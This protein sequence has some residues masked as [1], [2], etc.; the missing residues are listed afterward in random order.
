MEQLAIYLLGSFEVRLADQD[1]GGVFRTRKERALLAYLAVESRHP[2]RRE[3]LAE[4]L[5]PERPEGYART[6]LRQALLGLRK[7]IG[8]S[9]IQVTDELIHFRVGSSTWLDASEFRSAYLGTLSHSHPSLDSC[10]ECARLLEKAVEL[11]RGDFLDE[12]SLPDSPAFQEWSVFQREQHRRYLLAALQSLSDYHK[13]QRNYE[14]AY[15]YAWRYV[16]LAPLEETAYRQLMSVLALSGRR[17]AALEQFNACRSLLARELGVEP[18]VETLALYELIRSGQLA[19][20]TPATPRMVTGNLPSHL[21]SFYGREAELEH[22]EHCLV[23]Q[24]CRLITLVGMPGAGKTRLAMQ[25]ARHRQDLFHDGVWYIDLKEGLPG[26][27]LAER[28]LYT[29]G[30]TVQLSA[31]ALEQLY[32]QLHKKR[33]LLVVDRFEGYHAETGL[34]IE[35]LRRE[36]G[37]KILITSQ[38]RINYQSACVFVVGGLPYQVGDDPAGALES[39]AVQL[40]LGR[41]QHTRSGFKIDSHNLANITKICRLVEGLPLGVELA[42]SALPRAEQ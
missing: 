34:L 27:G 20:P 19:E 3:A 26:N 8:E 11:Y 31:P 15:Q 21:T 39:P 40:F 29:L 7:V 1:L 22:L 24:E 16:N 4:L 32:H 6:N 23:N 28:L 30:V 41:A 14:A 17:S 36:P 18:A 10:P 33:C 5:W 37:V 35:I 9:H 38:E 2:L 25:A 12:V 42:A 13:Q